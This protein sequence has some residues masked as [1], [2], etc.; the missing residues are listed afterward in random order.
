[1]QFTPL[2]YLGRSSD[3]HGEWLIV[4]TN[5]YHSVQDVGRVSQVVMGKESNEARMTYCSMRNKHFREHIAVASC[6]ILDF[7]EDYGAIYENAFNQAYSEM[8]SSSIERHFDA[9]W[10][11]LFIQRTRTEDMEVFK[12][13][14]EDAFSNSY[15]IIRDDYAFPE[16]WTP[17]QRMTYTICCSQSSMCKMQSHRC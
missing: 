6:D 15:N 7:I 5:N 2:T 16:D 11:Q 10:E 4:E 3:E 17:L 1:V 13:A 9:T 12:N 8:Y 14:C